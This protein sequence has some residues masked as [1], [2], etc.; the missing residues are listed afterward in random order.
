MSSFHRCDAIRRKKYRQEGHWGDATLADY[1]NMSVLCFPE[2]M[3]VI[4]SHGIGSTY[5][6]ADVRANQIASFLIK[7]GIKAGDFVSFQL[8][9]WCEFILIYIACMKVGAVANPIIPNYGICEL[10]YMLNKCESKVLFMPD[11]FRKC[12]HAGMVDELYTQ[13]RSLKS[14]VIVEKH[15][16]YSGSQNTLKRIFEDYS[17]I[18]K[19]YTRVSSD[20]LAAVIFTSGT[21]SMPKGVMLTHNNLIAS[22]KA[23]NNVFNINYSDTML[24]PAPVAHATGFFHGVVSPTMVG[25][26]TV[27]QDIFDCVAS[28]ELMKKHACTY[29]MGATTFVHDILTCME[30]Q[31]EPI[32]S[33]R[34]FLCGGAPIP[35]VMAQR[36]L[37]L[38]L[39]LISVYGATESAPHTATRPDE[40]LEKII[41]TD[42]KALPGIEVRV[43]NEKHETLPVHTQ[44]EEA[45]RGPNVF[46]G[47]LKEPE[48]TRK[49]LDEEGWY[50]SG[51]FCVMDEDGYIWVTGRKKD[52]II[53][54][55]ENI[56]PKEIEEIL[57]HHEKIK[58][59]AV[60]SMPDVRLGERACAYV[61]LKSGSDNF[62]FEE[63]IEIFVQMKV[64]KFKYPERLEI[65]KDLPKTSSGKIRKNVLRE[66]IRQ[67]IL[68]EKDTNPTVCN[69]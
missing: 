31:S 34:F 30:E 22:E 32:P 15:S 25:A 44:G 60:V 24:M 48:L 28:V 12:H 27:L 17:L 50:Y 52:V 11:R 61:V 54:G 65:V 53:R 4:D 16:E 10:V 36:S 58:E 45:S 9:G 38:G 41:H 35:R 67:K 18:D 46:A 23:F 56:S 42:G 49:V 40:S 68:A 47:Y 6:Q 26:T 1:W 5:A 39:K 2:K 8:P 20:D 63:M 43:V 55:G 64:A 14:I 19:A 7:T 57:L 33:L 13:V 3:A 59:A 51:D 66:K 62:T 29:M 37:N 21:E 69:T